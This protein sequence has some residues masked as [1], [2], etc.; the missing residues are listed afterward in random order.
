MR[1]EEL[2]VVVRKVVK[3][4]VEIEGI[5][6]RPVCGVVSVNHAEQIFLVH[7]VWL[8]I[9]ALSVLENFGNSQN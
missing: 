1:S 9:D 7:P 2:W 5:S 8:L 3:V 6:W 4:L